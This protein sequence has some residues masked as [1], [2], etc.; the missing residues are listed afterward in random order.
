MS[1]DTRAPSIAS[2]PTPPRP[3]RGPIHSATRTT[4]S[5]STN[6]AHTDSTHR[7][8][9]S[10]AHSAP[11]VDAL[12]RAVARPPGRTAI[13]PRSSPRVRTWS[14]EARPP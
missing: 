3:Q 7:R 8:R 9:S 6:R 13:G 12:N 10:G 11:D 5:F 2:R 4:A 14:A 1:T